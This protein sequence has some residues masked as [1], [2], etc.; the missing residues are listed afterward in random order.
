[1]WSDT[2]GKPIAKLDKSHIEK[3]YR[4]FDY[5]LLVQYALKYMQNY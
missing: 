5:I 4:A 3:Y 1:V 2:A